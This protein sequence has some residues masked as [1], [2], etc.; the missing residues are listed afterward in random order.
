M[1]VS[2]RTGY[3]F[4]KSKKKGTRKYTS[5]VRLNP[6]IP[7]E[8]MHAE[9]LSSSASYVILTLLFGPDWRYRAAWENPR[10]ALRPT[11]AVLRE[12]AIPLLEMLQDFVNSSSTVQ[13]LLKQ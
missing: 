11:E 7:S 5:V 10:A 2:M 13:T 4:K 3:Q 8:V 1:L 9:S 6:E 12:P